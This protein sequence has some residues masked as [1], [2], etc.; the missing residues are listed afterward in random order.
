MLAPSDWENLQG[1]T[2]HVRSPLLAGLRRLGTHWFTGSLDADEL[3]NILVMTLL[4]F[5]VAAPSRRL[6]D[7]AAALTRGGI[8]ADQ[9]ELVKSYKT[10]RDTFSPQQLTAAPILVAER[11]DGP[12]VLL[13]GY[14]RLSAMTTLHECQDLPISAIDVILGVCDHL[15]EWCLNDDG[16][17]RLHAEPPPEGIASFSPL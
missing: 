11:K 7:F 6:S 4:D 9:K 5:I 1:A 14:A 8:S 17:S 12:Y 13:E 3:P 15:R 2:C 16:V 10:I